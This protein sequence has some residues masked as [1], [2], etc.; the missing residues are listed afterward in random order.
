M[1][2]EQATVPQHVFEPVLRPE[3][4]YSHEL[5]VP[6]GSLVLMVGPPGSGKSTFAEKHFPNEAIVPTDGLRQ[7]LTNNPGNQLISEDAFNLAAHIVS[8]RLKHGKTTVLDAMNLDPGLRQRFTAFA[9]ENNAH[10]IAIYFDIPEE[11]LIKRDSQRLKSVGESYLRTRAQRAQEEIYGLEHDPTVDVLYKLESEASRLAQVALSDYDREL[12][13]KDIAFAQDVRVAEV[14]LMEYVAEQLRQSE[15]LTSEIPRLH[16]ERGTVNFFQDIQ[17]TR[18]FLRRNVL[19]SQVIDLSWVATRLGTTTDDVAVYH[20]AKKLIMSREGLN[21]TTFVICNDA[22]ADLATRLYQK[23]TRAHFHENLDPEFLAQAVL[24]VDDQS[25]EDVPLLILGDIHG[26]LTALR[27]HERNVFRENLGLTADQPKRKL[28]FVGDI[29][30][31]GPYD[32][33]AI[34]FVTALVRNREA[35]WIKGNHDVN[36][37][38]G[39]SYIYEHAQAAQSHGIS[40]E[41]WLLSLDFNE[42]KSRVLSS[43]TQETIRNLL[44]SQDRTGTLKAR[45]KLNS[46]QKIL[47]VLRDAPTYKRYKHLVAV[48]GSLPRIPRA[49]EESSMDKEKIHTHGLKQHGSQWT[50]RTEVREMPTI[51]AKDPD[52]FV[53][54]GHTHKGAYVNEISGVANLDYD[55]GNRGKIAAMYWMGSRHGEV[56]YEQEPSMLKLYEQLHRSSLPT[57]AELIDFLNYVR[58]Q[59]MIETKTGQVGTVYEGLTIINYSPITELQGLWEQY[60]SLR[61][62]RGLIVDADGRVVARPFKK[63]HKAGVEIPLDLLNIT[64]D[65]VFEKANGSMGICYHHAGSWHI[66]TKFSFDNEAY[67][68]VAKE[69]LDELNTEALD[70]T[71]TYLFEIILRDDPHIVNYDGQQKLILLNA[72]NTQ[73]GQELSWH[74]VA[75]TAKRLGSELVPDMTAFFTGRTIAELYRYA[76]TPGNLLNMEGLMAQYFDPQQNETVTIKIK[77]VDYDKKKFVRDRLEWKRLIERFDW[78]RLDLPAEEKEKMLAYN[79]DD[80]FVRCA[81]EARIL[82]MR[83]EYTRLVRVVQDFVLDPWIEARQV[84]ENA[85]AAEAN[86]QKAVSRAMSIAVAAISEKFRKAGVYLQQGSQNA[87]L[88]FVR[89]ILLD[90][91]RAYEKLDMYAREQ[92]QGRIE[93]EIARR[94]KASYWLTPED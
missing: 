80:T 48:H 63:T 87:V 5:D 55:G 68:K 74:E 32:A 42:V 46:L 54:S 36:L 15:Q 52:V 39:L 38:N 56:T 10:V 4:L 9:R 18:E 57:G 91:P 7:E 65:K 33:E 21:L 2:D 20:F 82:W 24:E 47:E 45:I 50:G 30:D 35:I 71:N 8:S 64:P 81:L 29:A 31:R 1:R 83:S 58:G 67:T 73:S 53:V 27:A 70:P 37:E 85:I 28:L 84:Y 89:A 72:T 69:M 49:D 75:A 88:G 11:E 59:G 60:P 76:Q 94:G 66:A 41:K 6:E 23:T 34:L 51:V 22:T 17:A 92:I 44:Y 12:L 16:I 78:Q 13:F 3:V 43:D 79:R 62:F 14:N 19:T 61:N 93:A 77:A 26:C 86:Q 25:D 90:D 40:W